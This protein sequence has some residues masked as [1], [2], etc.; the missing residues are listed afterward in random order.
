MWKI[1][2]SNIRLQYE[3][4][5]QEVGH[6][7]QKTLEDSRLLWGEEV[8]NFERQFASL[9]GVQ[10]CISTGNGTDSLFSI[11]KVLGLKTGD[12]VITP[13]FS[14]ISSA[15]T[16]SLTGAKPIFVDVDPSRYTLDPNRIEKSITSQTRAVIVVHLYGQAAEMDKIVA[17]CKKHRLFLIEDCAQAHLTKFKTQYAGS[18]GDASAFSFYPTKNLGAYGDA[19]CVVTNNQVLA[20]KVRRF[21]NHGA[22]KKHDHAIEGSN[23]RM[24]TI[25]AA[26][27]LA[28][29]PHLEG[30]TQLRIEKANMYRAGLQ[31]VAEVILPTQ[32]EESVHSYHLFVIRCVRRAELQRHLEENGIQT[33]IHYPQA[34]INIQAYDHLTIDP[35]DF[36]A[37]LALETGALSL[38]LYPELDARQIT[39]VCQKIKA[40][41]RK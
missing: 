31:D 19:G 22:L 5:R 6:A 16:I 36:P 39:Y 24:D 29:L 13:A 3:S 17:L 20:E 1:P 14:W 15:E 8:F 7:I 33:L 9:L 41:Y 28:K 27:L 37:S 35:I 23:S 32:F 30:W 25:Q 4:I 12:E 40:F 11:L 21:N 34:L 10:H 38:P 18:F 2:F 26:I